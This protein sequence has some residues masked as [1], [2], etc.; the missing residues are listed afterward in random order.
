MGGAAVGGI[1]VAGIAGAAMTRMMD[2][3]GL[4]GTFKS[5]CRTAKK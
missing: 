4:V 5:V 3:P 2:V 1:Q